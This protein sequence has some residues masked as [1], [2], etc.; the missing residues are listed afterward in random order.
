MYDWA[1]M[2]MVCNVLLDFLDRDCRTEKIDFIF[3]KCSELRACIE[4]YELERDTKFPPS[5]RRICGE[6]IPGDDK[7]LA[8]LQ[9]ADLLAGEHSVY[10]RTNMKAA[11]YAE[12]ENARIPVLAFSG[13]PPREAIELTM[14]YAQEVAQ[15]HNLVQAMLK[16]CK[17]NGVN[18]DDFK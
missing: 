10:L 12:I 7:C 2:A 3:D 18:L 5:M 1:F 11:P 6:A 13:Q 14:Q 8:G 15:R 4:G 17:E 16:V 9:A